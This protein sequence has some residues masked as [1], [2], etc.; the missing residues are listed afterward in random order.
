MSDEPAWPVHDLLAILIS[1]PVPKYITSELADRKCDARWD[2]R[3]RSR[4]EQEAAYKTNDRPEH[5]RSRRYKHV[6]IF[7]QKMQYDR[8]CHISRV[9]TFGL[10]GALG[11]AI[12]PC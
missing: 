12:A 2:E 1:E 6:L 8:H 11:W 7:L 5:E 10:L 3:K 9:Y 4:F